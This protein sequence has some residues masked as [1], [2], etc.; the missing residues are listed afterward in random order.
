M[1][2]I[3]YVRR[4]SADIFLILFIGF[5]RY[6]TIFIFPDSNIFIKILTDALFFQIRKY[7]IKKKG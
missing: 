3:G 5:N 2:R 4:V 1:L 7:K 6:F